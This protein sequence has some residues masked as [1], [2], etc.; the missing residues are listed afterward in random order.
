MYHVYGVLGVK[1][2]ADIATLGFESTKY[3]GMT[4]GKMKV[5]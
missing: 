3:T 2:S 1:Y 5:S 4:E